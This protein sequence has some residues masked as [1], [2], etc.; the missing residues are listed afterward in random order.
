MA[1]SITY[2][3]SEVW[4]FGQRLADDELEGDVGEEEDE[5]ELETVGHES[6]AHS[7]RREDQA[8]DEHLKQREER[9]L[10]EGN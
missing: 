6:Q 9:C 7:E 10:W 2:E 1:V 8:T 4:D 5:W 3:N